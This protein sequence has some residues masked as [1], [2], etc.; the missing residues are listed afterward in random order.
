MTTEPTGPAP[1]RRDPLT[2]EKVLRTAMAMA[3]E[4]GAGVPSMRKLAERLGVEAMTLYHHFRNKEVI[5][6]HMVDAVFAEIELPSGEADWKDAMRGRAAS[7]REALVRHRWAIGLMDSRADSGRARL[8]HHDAVIG[9]LRSGGFSITGAAHAFSVLDGY[10]YGFVLQEI[11]LPLTASDEVEAAADALLERL[12]R[13][14]FPH[15]A[16]MITGYASRPGYAYG[17]EFDVGLELIVEGLERR[18]ESWR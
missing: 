17:D 8:R 15:L 13:E 7:M 6:D 3:D 4:S 10:V 5:L 9:C 2:K 11:S 14:E 12:P 1:A 18:R 16:E